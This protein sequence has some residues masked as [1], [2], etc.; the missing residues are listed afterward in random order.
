ML[1]TLSA[2][3]NVD[4]STFGILPLVGMYGPR[5]EIPQVGKSF[6]NEVSANLAW[7]EIVDIA[8]ITGE[9]DCCSLV[10]ND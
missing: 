5:L 1:P 6:P 2:K 7:T 4:T 10:K 3:D 8:Q 9:C